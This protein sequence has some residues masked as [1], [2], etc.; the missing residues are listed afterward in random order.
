MQLSGDDRR[1]PIILAN[2]GF[3]CW[4][5]YPSIGPDRLIKLSA[6]LTNVNSMQN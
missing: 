1:Q 3:H 4:S 2:D 6:T 5:I